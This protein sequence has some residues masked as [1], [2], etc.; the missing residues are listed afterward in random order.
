MWAN[1][2]HYHTKQ[3]ARLC[4]LIFTCLDSKLEDKRFCSERQQ[5]LPDFNVLLISSRLEFWFVVTFPNVPLA[6]SL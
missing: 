4:I 3:Q 5:A 1:N 2:L 6:L